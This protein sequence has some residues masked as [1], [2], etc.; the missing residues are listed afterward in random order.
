MLDAIQVR[1]ALIG[2]AVAAF[3]LFGSGIL[4]WDQY[5]GIRAPHYAFLV[6][7]GVWFWCTVAVRFIFHIA[8]T[9]SG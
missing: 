1:S 6:C 8:N 5:A 2:A 3:V 4:T 7:S 9:K